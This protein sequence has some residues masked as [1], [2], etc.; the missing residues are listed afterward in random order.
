MQYYQFTPGKPVISPDSGAQV[1]DFTRRNLEALRDGVLM[2]QMPGW[3]CTITPSTLEPTAIYYSLGSAK[4]RGIITWGTAG[5]E[6]GNI[7]TIVFTLSGDSGGTYPDP[8]GTLNFS[9][10]GAGTLA[11]PAGFD[12]SNWT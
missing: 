2:G 8:V 4:L 6:A 10:S 7:K 1:I 11:S 12:G 3:A 5:A 9:Y